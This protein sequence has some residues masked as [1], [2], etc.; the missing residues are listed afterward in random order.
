MTSNTALI[1]GVIIVLL[2]AGTVGAGAVAGTGAFDADVQEDDDDGE[3]DD[4]DDGEQD[5]DHD[6]GDEHDDN[7][8]AAMPAEGELLEVR[9]ATER[10]T[11]VSAAEEAGYVSTEVCEAHD[12]AAMGIHYV[13]PGLMNDTELN[14]TQPEI[15][16]YEPTEDGLE[17]VAVEYFVAAV[18]WHEEHDRETPRIFG[19]EFDGPMAGHTP[20][21][22]VHYDQHVWLWKPN[23]R[24]L[25]AGFNP[26]VSC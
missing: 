18:P 13:N 12:G 7:E 17:L 24:G 6:D 5:H 3:Q 19:E 11:N 10:F 9:N 25:F 8:S 26:F 16:L 21:M 1:S 2:V 15:L 22:P 14:A 4:D 20:D 23:P